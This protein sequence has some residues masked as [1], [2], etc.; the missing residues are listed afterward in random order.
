MQAIN[1]Q[2]TDNVLSLALELGV[3]RSIHVSTVWAFG[4]S[5]PALRDE[6]FTRN[7]SYRSAYEQTKVEAHAIAREYQQRGLPLVIVLCGESKSLRELFVYWA[8]RPGA[9][10]SR[11]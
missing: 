4:Y 2:G 10:K 6:T 8:G 7:A 5:G 9:F 3:P 1:T 11:F